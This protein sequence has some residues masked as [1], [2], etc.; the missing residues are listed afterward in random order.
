MN[1]FNPLVGHS[2][3]KTFNNSINTQTTMQDAINKHTA[4]IAAVCDQYGDM[5]PLLYH[6]LQSNEGLLAMAKVVQGC[7]IAG[8][9]MHNKDTKG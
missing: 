4:T 1:D 6:I 8:L 3:E 5:I 7:D 2:A 9:A